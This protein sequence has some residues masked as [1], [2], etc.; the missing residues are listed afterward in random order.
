MLKIENIFIN[1]A[2]GKK[3]IVKGV[4]L[5]FKPSE[6]HLLNGKNGS[7]KSTLVNTIWVTLS[8]Q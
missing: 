4:S 5:D 3:E 2:E 7:G 8:I 1:L 6:V